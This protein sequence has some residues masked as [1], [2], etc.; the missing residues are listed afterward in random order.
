M[1][2]AGQKLNRSR[3]PKRHVPPKNRRKTGNA[4]HFKKRNQGGASTQFKK[5]QTGNRYGRPRTA[6]FSKEVRLFLRERDLKRK[7]GEARLLTLLERLLRDDPKQL[8]YYAYGKP[9]D[10]VQL[11]GADG[12][13]GA[14]KWFLDPEAVTGPAPETLLEAEAARP[15][16][17]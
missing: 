1:S 15:A 9:M 10:T 16:R 14:V 6:E 7:D 17:S 3:K 4:G 11:Q 12:G 5:G 13:A 2:A 8:L